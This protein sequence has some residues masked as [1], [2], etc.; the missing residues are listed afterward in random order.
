MLKSISAFVFVRSREVVRFWEGPLREA[1][2]SGWWD[3]DVTS[4]NHQCADKHS[5]CGVLKGVLNLQCKLLLWINSHVGSGAWIQL[6]DVKIVGMAR[7][8][9]EIVMCVWLA[10]CR[11]GNS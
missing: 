7:I 4:C 11:D 5:N 8:W 9:M 6:L 1:P 2:L 3:Y 10:R